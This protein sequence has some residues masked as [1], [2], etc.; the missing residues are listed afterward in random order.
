[1]SPFCKQNGHDY[2]LRSNIVFIIYK[3]EIFL[4]HSSS[5]TLFLQA[6]TMNVFVMLTLNIFLFIQ[7]HSIMFI[8]SN[9]FFYIFQNWRNVLVQIL[10]DCYSF[11]KS[12]FLLTFCDEISMHKKEE[13][14]FVN[15][16]NSTTS[17]FHRTTK[18]LLV[19]F[20]NENMVTCCTIGPL[21]SFKKLKLN[22]VFRCYRVQYYINI[23]Y[24]VLM[25][26]LM[27]MYS[28]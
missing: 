3:D 2:S 5:I 16:Y 28:K 23:D 9:N 19:T 18:K 21:S 8:V 17:L 4:L 25:L 14:R 15:N 26:W 11:H 6:T 10:K 20:R 13:L 27:L 24:V 22:F 7:K 1:M 12:E